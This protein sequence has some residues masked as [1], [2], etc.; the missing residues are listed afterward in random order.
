MSIKEVSRVWPGEGTRTMETLKVAA[1]FQPQTPLLCRK[2]N[3]HDH[4]FG[5]FQEKMNIGI[6]GRKHHILY[7][8]QKFSLRNY[9]TQG[10]TNKRYIRQI[11]H[12]ATTLR[13]V[14]HI[15]QILDSSLLAQVD[16]QESQLAC[17]SLVHSASAGVPCT[18]LSPMLLPLSR[19]HI[20]TQTPYPLSG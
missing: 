3:Q 18:C 7:S 4:M 11:C 2:V 1:L 19:H 14:V 20:M 9:R 10:S 8:D 17:C 5:I 12:R 6:F 13:P 16:L 15:K